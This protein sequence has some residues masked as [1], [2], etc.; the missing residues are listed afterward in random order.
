MRSNRPSRCDR[1]RH[2][3]YAAG[4]TPGIAGLAATP[5]PDRRQ[6]HLLCSREPGRGYTPPTRPSPRR[7]GR[8]FLTARLYEL[9]DYAGYTVVD[10]A[11]VNVN[12]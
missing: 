8:G 6:E 10:D 11:I 4:D 9:L 7:A 12:D 2:L 1:V 5:A 3:A